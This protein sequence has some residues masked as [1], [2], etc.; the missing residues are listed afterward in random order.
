MLPFWTNSKV[1]G[2]GASGSAQVWPH[3]ILDTRRLQRL[4]KKSPLLTWNEIQTRAAP[5]GQRKVVSWIS[6]C[7]LFV[8]P[9]LVYWLTEPKSDM[10]Q[11]L[12][13]SFFKRDS[14]CVFSLH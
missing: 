2:G 14:D 13:T 4:Q 3:K 5:A 8:A 10:W 12:P 6:L 9:F 7:L 1:E 11:E